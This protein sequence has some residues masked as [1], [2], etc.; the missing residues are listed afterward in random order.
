[1][2]QLDHTALTEGL[3]DK[4]KAEFAGKIRVI[5]LSSLNEK[6]TDM[7]I[8]YLATTVNNLVPNFMY[9]K[10]N[11]CALNVFTANAQQIKPAVVLIFCGHSHHSGGLT[12]YLSEACVAKIIHDVNPT[13]VSF[14]GCDVG[15]PRWL[16]SESKSLAWSQHRPYLCGLQQKS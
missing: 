4:L 15:R 12:A 16:Y 2:I 9:T 14:F 8:P 5:N 1:L 13:V 3:I 6:N 10:Q 11:S 7:N